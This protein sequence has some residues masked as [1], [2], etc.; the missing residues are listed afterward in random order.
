[1]YWFSVERYIVFFQTRCQASTRGPDRLHSTDHASGGGCCSLLYL[2]KEKVSLP[3]HVL[4]PSAS[5]VPSFLF[6]P[7]GLSLL[8][9]LIKTSGDS[10]LHLPLLKFRLS[11]L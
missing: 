6:S 10:S 7:N 11:R 5:L 1:M 8:P 3:V 9:A 4:L 2:E